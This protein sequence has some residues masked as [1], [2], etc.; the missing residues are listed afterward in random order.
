MTV[1]GREFFL[2]T[3]N[4]FHSVEDDELKKIQRKFMLQ[5]LKLTPYALTVEIMNNKS[6]ITNKM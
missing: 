2:V 6:K 4:N 3:N 5:W 1:I